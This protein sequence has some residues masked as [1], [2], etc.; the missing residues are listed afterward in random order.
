MKALGEN[1]TALSEGIARFEQAG[2]SQGRPASE[3][4]DGELPF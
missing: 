4:E 1:E 3:P 2:R